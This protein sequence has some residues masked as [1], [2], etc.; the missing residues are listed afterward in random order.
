MTKFAVITGTPKVDEMPTT[1]AEGAELAKVELVVKSIATIV[2]RHRRALL[3]DLGFSTSSGPKST[4]PFLLRNTWR[5][6]IFAGWRHL[7]A[8]RESD[9]FCWRRATKEPILNFVETP[10]IVSSPYM[11]THT[12]HTD[13]HL[14][15]KIFGAG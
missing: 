5:S 10:K 12:L 11:Y 4:L 3:Q 13:P 14:A 9:S 6:M 7:A 15:V 8:G 2:M 1:F